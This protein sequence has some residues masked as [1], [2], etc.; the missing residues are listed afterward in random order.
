MIIIESSDPNLLAA[1]AQMKSG[2]KL[3]SNFESMP[4]LILPLGPVARSKA[5]NPKT[6]VGV[7]SGTKVETS[8]TGGCNR[9]AGV[10]LRF[11]KRSE[12]CDL[13]KTAKE[14]LHR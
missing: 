9:S 1:I 7:M 2:K 5:T 13:R 6:D 8:S 3:K 12:H 14:V 11:H 10:D 4:S